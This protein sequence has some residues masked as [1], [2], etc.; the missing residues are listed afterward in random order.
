MRGLTLFVTVIVV[1]CVCLSPTM[2]GPVR[3]SWFHDAPAVAPTLTPV[4][5]VPAVCSPAKPVPAACSP[6]AAMTCD[7]ITVGKARRCGL[8]TGV[9][10]ASAKAAA[11]PVRLICHHRE[12]KRGC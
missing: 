9:V 1:C 11:V 12:K 8:V 10:R 7:E 2:G 4:A 3:G 5:P 6:A